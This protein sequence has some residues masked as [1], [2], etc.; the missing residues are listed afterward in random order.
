MEDA[1][2]AGSPLQV[3]D[4]RAADDVFAVVVGERAL[5]LAEDVASSG[6]RPSRG[7]G[8]GDEFFVQDVVET[9]AG[10]AGLGPRLVPRRGG[11]R[12][13]DASSD[14]AAS[15]VSEAEG[16]GSGN[17]RFLRGAR[18]GSLETPR[19][20]HVDE[21]LLVRPSRVAAVALA[22]VFREGIRQSPPASGQARVERLRRATAHLSRASRRGDDPRLARARGIVRT[23]RE[24]RC[25]PRGARHVSD[26]ASLIGRRVSNGRRD[27][28]KRSR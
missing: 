12:W 24:R 3:V 15:L 9:R 7:D 21:G 18:R 1:A 22:R 26:A 16:A 23:H 10:D 11:W 4:A 28:E 27:R 5:N 25:A 14:V 17:G 13:D 20:E 8:P 19:E 2:G 6:A